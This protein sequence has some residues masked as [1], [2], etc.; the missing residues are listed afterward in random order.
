[1]DFPCFKPE[2]WV[3]LSNPRLPWEDSSCSVAMPAV[4]IGRRGLGRSQLG[5]RLGVCHWF[6]TWLIAAPNVPT[7]LGARLESQNFGRKLAEAN[8]TKLFGIFL[9]PLITPDIDPEHGQVLVGTHPP[10]S[11]QRLCWFG[12]GYYLYNDYI[13][14][15]FIMSSKVSWGSLRSWD[16]T[17]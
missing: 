6:R 2:I 11:W 10:D 5:P 3:P 1:M 14:D 13:G 12:S 7:W 16:C 8:L 17:T 9:G 15:G 4:A